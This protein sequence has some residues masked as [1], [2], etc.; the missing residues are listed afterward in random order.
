MLKQ[1]VEDQRLP[2]RK[3]KFEM[4][5]ETEIRSS[6][7]ASRSLKELFEYSDEGVL[8][9]KVDPLHPVP[10]WVVVQTLKRYLF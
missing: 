5:P 4:L 10:K 2:S 6:E 3:L 8:E 7:H 1:V 9:I